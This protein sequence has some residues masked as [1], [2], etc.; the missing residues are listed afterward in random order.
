MSCP[1]RTGDPWGASSPSCSG[2]IRSAAKGDTIAVRMA[3]VLVPPLA[4]WVPTSDAAEGSGLALYKGLLRGVRAGGAA[5]CRHD[6]EG[7]TEGKLS[8]LAAAR[9]RDK[10]MEEL[11][12]YLAVSAQPPCR[13]KAC[14]WR[15]MRRSTSPCHFQQQ[16]LLSSRRIL[17]LAASQGPM[18]PCAASE[19]Q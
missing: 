18:D 16:V 11:Q 15:E 14:R 1:G 17:Q 3:P 9:L 6:S 12:V 8:Q 13:C 5:S 7:D 10:I 4:V 2:S 19:V